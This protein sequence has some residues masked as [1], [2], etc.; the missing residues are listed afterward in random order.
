VAFCRQAATFPE[1][2][3]TADAVVLTDPAALPAIAEACR[4]PATAGGARLDIR[5]A[6]RSVWRSSTRGAAFGVL[7]VGVL[8]GVV[9]RSDGQFLWVAPRREQAAGSS[10]LDHIV[11]GGVPAGLTPDETLVKEAEEEA[12]IPAFGAPGGGGDDHLCDGASGGTASR[13]AHCYDLDLP[14]DFCPRAADGGW[15]HSN[16]GRS[17]G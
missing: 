8:N 1:I 5:R 7:A 17:S 15:R 4:M 14:E 6:G 10:K 9:R 11:A 3:A 12:A 13:S 16:S 2:R